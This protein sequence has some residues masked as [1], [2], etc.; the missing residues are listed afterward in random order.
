MSGIRERPVQ[1]PWGGLRRWGLTS[2]LVMSQSL[3]AWLWAPLV[4]IWKPLAVAVCG[5]TGDRRG[6]RG[7]LGLCLGPQLGWELQTQKPR[8]GQ[9]MQDLTLPRPLV[10]WL[11][12]GCRGR[13]LGGRSR[14]GL[15]IDGQQGLIL[16]SKVHGDHSLHG[17]HLR[18]DLH[19]LLWGVQAFRD[20]QPPPE[21]PPPQLPSRGHAQGLRHGLTRTTF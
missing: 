16:H 17:Q 15:L 1:R 8:R 10:A 18:L 12:F 7:H 11:T 6:G 9:Q 2:T 4:T 3:T 19:E 13:A 14:L 5:S 20:L 21:R